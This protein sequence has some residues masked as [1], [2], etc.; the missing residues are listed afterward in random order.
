MG[1]LA[2]YIAAI[3]LIISLWFQQAKILK[4]AETSR[5]T[6][7]PKEKILLQVSEFVIVLHLN[8]K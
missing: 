8:K 4:M 6:F 1:N 5:V 3:L 2:C 7:S